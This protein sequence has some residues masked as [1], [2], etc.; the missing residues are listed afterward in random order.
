M[1]N[2]QTKFPLHLISNQPDN[3][4]HSQLD[5]GSHSRANKIDGREPIRI[6]SLDAT[7][8]NLKSNDLVLVFNDRGSCL[9]AVVVDDGI[10]SGVALMSTGAWYDPLDP[11]IVNSTCKN[12]NPNVLTPDK[13]TSSLAQGP[14][15]HT[16]LVEIK[17]VNEPMPK[18]TA[19][20]P[21]KI[22]RKEG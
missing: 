20:D 1:G 13:G 4:L 18:V 6:N 17:L 12:G 19:Y 5:H 21:P 8:R 2:N 15:A 10:R 3:K 14:I 7:K 22:I 11:S 9:A 16:C